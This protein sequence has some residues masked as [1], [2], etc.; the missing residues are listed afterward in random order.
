M[1]A[2]NFPSSSSSSS[3]SS[4][5]PLRSSRTRT[6]TRT[7]TI[8]FALLLF[9]AATGWGAGEGAL[10]AS[11]AAWAALPL[12]DITL[13]P[14]EQAL[15]VL[16]VVATLLGYHFIIG[17]YIRQQA[18]VE[19][20]SHTEIGG[21]PITIKTHV[22]F[23]PVPEFREF[24]KYVHDREHDILNKVQAVQNG[25]D[26]RRDEIAEMHTKIDEK[27]TEAIKASNSSASKVHGRI[28]D[29]ASTQGQL[30]GELRQMNSNIQLLLGRGMKK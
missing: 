27:F 21:Q 8:L 12:A 23:L 15:A 10:P 7:R 9:G 3:S 19:E 4:S 28:D 25:V 29:L 5:L 2:L 11:E 30:V 26:E 16:G 22:D 17:R 20:T 6:R 24:E 18:G 14:G 1:S 13:S